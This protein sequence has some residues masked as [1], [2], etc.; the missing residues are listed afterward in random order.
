[1][2]IDI[3]IFDFTNIISILLGIILFS[4]LIILAIKK[5]KNY[6][7]GILTVLCFLLLIGHIIEWI[8][9][10]EKFEEYSKSIIFDSIAL[11]ISNIILIHR[12]YKVKKETK[13]EV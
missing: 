2:K 6:I 10:K 7:I 8:I 11:I 5:N 9:L 3:P 13:E 1:M 4:L 12:T